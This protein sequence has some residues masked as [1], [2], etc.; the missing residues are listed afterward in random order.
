MNIILILRNVRNPSLQK[1]KP[2]VK[3][4]KKAK[5]KPNLGNYL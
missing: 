4:K 5:T 2:K 3:G 1:K